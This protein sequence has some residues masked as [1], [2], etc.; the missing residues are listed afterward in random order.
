MGAFEAQARVD[1]QDVERVA[2][3]MYCDY[4]RSAAPPVAFH[5]RHDLRMWTKVASERDRIAW[6]RSA[7]VAIEAMRPKSR[8]VEHRGAGEMAFR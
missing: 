6:R 3:A 5:P 2:I 1:D 4:L 7:A 8:A